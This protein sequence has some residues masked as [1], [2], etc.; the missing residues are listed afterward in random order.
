MS[1]KYIYLY[2]YMYIFIIRYALNIFGCYTSYVVNLYLICAIPCSPLSIFY[3]CI[4]YIPYYIPYYKRCFGFHAIYYVE[5]VHIYNCTYMYMYLCADIH[6]I[7]YMMQSCIA[8][9]HSCKQSK[10][11]IFP[12]MYHMYNKVNGFNLIC[13]VIYCIILCHIIQF[14]AFCAT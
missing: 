12:I 13:C 4:S 8:S 11:V 7:F 5:H 2:A 14:F 9:D 6:S 1:Y 10:H 3:C